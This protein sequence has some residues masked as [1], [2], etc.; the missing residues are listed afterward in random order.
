MNIP[1]EIFEKILDFKFLRDLKTCSNYRSDFSYYNV[2]L[3]SR[4]ML[5]TVRRHRFET[6]TFSDCT[7]LKFPAFLTS[8]EKYEQF[9]QWNRKMNLDYN[10]IKYIKNVNIISGKSF[11]L[12]NLFKDAPL[13]SL[14]SLTLHYIPP[15]TLFNSKKIPMFLQS[16]QT[17]ETLNVNLLNYKIGQVSRIIKSL[18]NTSISTISNLSIDHNHLL[19]ESTECFNALKKLKAL[20]IVSNCNLS[21]GDILYHNIQLS[22]L[23]LCSE[24]CSIQLSNFEFCITALKKLSLVFVSGQLESI[25]EFLKKATQ[26]TELEFLADESEKSESLTLLSFVKNSNHITD[27]TFMERS[28]KMI[29]SDCKLKHFIYTG[30]GYNIFKKN[31]CVYIN[32]CDLFKVD[33]I[34]YFVN[35]K[36]CK[37]FADFDNDLDYQVSIFKCGV[38]KRKYSCAN[39]VIQRLHK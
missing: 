32:S 8:Y 25:I 27:F 13:L 35:K 28:I 18:S 22:K 39:V 4:T 12:F 7:Y 26:L 17:L 6:V 34:E 9:L 3:V 19:Y 23:D 21:E 37:E 5:E 2:A 30:Y 14:Q 15:R 33:A 20:K 31:N 11:E 16:I 29:F 1:V 36:K 10:F 38:V 24:E